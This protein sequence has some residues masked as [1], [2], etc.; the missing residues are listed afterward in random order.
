MKLHIV[1]FK[2]FNRFHAN[3][4]VR[5]YADS[6][7]FHRFYFIFGLIDENSQSHTCA[8]VRPN[9]KPNTN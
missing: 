3:R 5:C 8:G 9:K 2:I 1:A 4:N 7:S 6:M